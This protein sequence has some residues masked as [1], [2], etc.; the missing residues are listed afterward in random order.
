M[1]LFTTIRAKYMVSKFTK[2][3]YLFLASITSTLAK[4]YTCFNKFFLQYK[5][6]LLN[7]LQIL[8]SVCQYLNYN[9]F[10]QTYQISINYTKTETNIYK[11]INKILLPNHTLLLTQE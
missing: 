10:L 2:D 4:K 5:I 6:L 11:N 3:S 8:G 9:N 1:T 7:T